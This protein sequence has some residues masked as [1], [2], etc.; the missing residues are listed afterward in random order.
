MSPSL[1]SL[2]PAILHGKLMHEADE[3]VIRQKVCKILF[4]L[5]RIV[6]PFQESGE[7]LLY[8]PLRFPRFRQDQ[9]IGE[10][11]VQQYFQHDRAEM[12][13]QKAAFYPELMERPLKTRG[14]RHE[15]QVQRKP[16]ADP[17]PEISKGDII[18][19]ILLPAN[20]IHRIRFD[21][22]DFF[23]MGKLRKKIHLEERNHMGIHLHH[24]D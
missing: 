18:G 9:R 22:M 21:D 2:T 19:P 15:S 3:T 17:S 7:S 16:I 4:R 11:H 12:V 1:Q 5:D 24:R 8:P 20:E 23:L 13:L 14:E 6:P 10:P